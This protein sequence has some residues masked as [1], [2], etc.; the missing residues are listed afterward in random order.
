M[1][2][3]HSFLYVYHGWYTT[4]QSSHEPVY[5]ENHQ[6]S[7]G[8]IRF[9]TAGRGIRHSEHNLHG[10]PLRFVQCWVM[11]RRFSAG[12]AEEALKGRGFS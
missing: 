8:A 2:I 5:P 4:N 7:T 1:V 3:F 12:I 6:R 9:M 10:E 11:P